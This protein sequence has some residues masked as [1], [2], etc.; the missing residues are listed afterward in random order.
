MATKPQKSSLFAPFWSK[1]IVSPH[2][3]AIN[4]TDGRCNHLR[5][6]RPHPKVL[7]K[8]LHTDVIQCNRAYDGQRIAQHLRQST[9]LNRAK[10]HIAIEPKSRQKG[11]RKDH[12]K[13]GYMWRHNHKAEVYKSFTDNVMI[14][15]VVP[16]PIE[17]H[18]RSST[19]QI[20]EDL[21]RK[22][23]MQRL[24]IE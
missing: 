8:A 21:L 7:D 23:S 17:Q 22:N 18:R 20:A 19:R 12:D 16:Y 11:N 6:C 1:C 14:D 4:S 10:R 15:Y 24:H 5:R 2:K 9:H 3:I 13:R